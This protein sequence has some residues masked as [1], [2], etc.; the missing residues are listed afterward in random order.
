MLSQELFRGIESKLASFRG[1][2]LACFPSIP[3][4]TSPTILLQD[5]FQEHF[6]INPNEWCLPFIFDS[7]IQQIF[8]SLPDSCTCLTMT[9]TLWTQKQDSV[10]ESLFPLES[11]NHKDQ[12]PQCQLLERAEAHGKVVATTA[13]KPAH[14]GEHV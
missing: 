4:P 5:F 7:F 1:T 11:Y 8:T 2:L 3:C 14:L 9:Q 6:L 13:M 10:P 12:S